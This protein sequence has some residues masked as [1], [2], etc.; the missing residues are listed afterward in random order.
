MGTILQK[1]D[2]L[3]ETKTQIKQAINRKVSGLVT[4]ATPFRQYADAI[5][6]IPLL[7]AGTDLLFHFTDVS[8]WTF[9][10][11]SFLT[12]ANTDFIRCWPTELPNNNPTVESAVALN[13]SASI[14]Q[15]V[16]IQ[17]CFPDVAT[18]GQIPKLYFKTNGDTEYAASNCVESTKQLCFENPWTS[19]E[20][21]MTGNA[22]W[23]GIVT[24]IRFAPFQCAGIFCLRTIGFAKSNAINPDAII[25]ESYRNDILPMIKYHSE[26]GFYDSIFGWNYDVNDLACTFNLNPFSSPW[27]CPMT[28]VGIDKRLLIVPSKARY[29]GTIY[30]LDFSSGGSKIVGQYF[31]KVYF[32]EGITSLCNNH[33]SFFYPYSENYIPVIEAGAGTIYIPSTVTEIDPGF[34]GNATIDSIVINQPIG[35]ISGAPWGAPASAQIQ[36]TGI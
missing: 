25:L 17:A 22:A 20:F 27:S 16:I 19:Y 5:D 11:C 2:F 18:P 30:S 24:G 13:L 8:N 28:K 6:M 14:Y 34:F 1:K 36:W 9:G 23:S 35:S 21:D 7:P 32:A 26:Y 4:N 33:Y 15:K 31:D 10:S 3:T 29:N 12:E